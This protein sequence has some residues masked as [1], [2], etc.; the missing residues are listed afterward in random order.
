M[1]V[2]DRAIW[3]RIKNVAAPPSV[4]EEH[5]LSSPLCRSFTHFSL[6]TGFL[7]FVP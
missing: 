4:P 1:T 5:V 3:G 6:Q 2:K 7:S